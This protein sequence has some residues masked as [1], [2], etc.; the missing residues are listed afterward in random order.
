ML[1]PVLADP[2]LIAID[3]VA[4]GV[5]HATTGYAAHRLRP[6]TLGRHGWLLGLRSFERDGRWYRRWQVDRW[7]D[8]LPEAGDL[9]AGGVSKRHLTSP[10]D[11][12]LRAFVLETRRAEV[13]H[14][15]ALACGPLFMLW[16]PPLASGLL[17]AY[18][19]VVNLPFI[20]VQ[21][22]NRAR[23]EGLLDRR[24]R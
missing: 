7:K 18:G 20:A 16:N 3:V 24:G 11:D 19:I 15:T 5:F 21:R 17:I 13:G 12:G 6:R 14:W 4:W 8:L 9:F 22:Y 1:A 23:V 10:D 2:V